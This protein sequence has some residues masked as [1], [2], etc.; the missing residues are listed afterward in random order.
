MEMTVNGY[1][2]PDKRVGFRNHIL[3]LPCSLCASETARFAAEGVPGALYLPNQGGC[4]LSK[5][6]LNITLEALS[7]IAMNPN[8]YGTVLIGNGCEVVQASL[9]A[10]VIKRKTNKPLE[11]LIIREEGG[12]VKTIQ[13][14]VELAGRMVAEANCLK[15]EKVSLSS[16]I[17]GTEC[18]G[19][20]PTSGLVSNPVLGVCSD[21][22]IDMGGTTIMS[23]TP[24]M[25]G[26]EAILA[27][28]CQNES[29]K[30]ELLN[31]IKNF[32]DE[33][34]NVGENP[35]NGNPTPGNIKGGITTLEEKSLGCIHKGG[36]K[37]IEEVLHYGQEGS[38]KGLLIMDTPGQDIAS[39]AGMAAAGAQI[40][41]FTTGHGTPTG[42][43]IVPVIKITA[44][45]ETAR[46]MREHIDFDCSGI[47]RGEDTIEAS[48]EQLLE[49]VA[50]V[51]NGEK[52]QA[53]V[54]GFQDMSIA[55]YCNFA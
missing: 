37:K 18:G 24:E 4:S 1:V 28:R 22:L 21:M 7:G 41:V 9:L 38:K 53:E 26:A 50:K 3:I 12:T 23:E 16:L 48:G 11:T 13:R 5:R 46:L 25:I 45:E 42:F 30:S 54:L 51:A 52:T 10:E 14:A 33:F 34:K 29:V 44:N 55:R 19:S 49:I 31:M 8:V 2:R 39:I 32:E 6:D 15:P 40:V 20:D 47:M 27:K 35:R 36:T 43:G 17:L